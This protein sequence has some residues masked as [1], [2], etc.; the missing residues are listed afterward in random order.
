MPDKSLRVLTVEQRLLFTTIP[1]NL[2]M[3]AKKQ[4][5]DPFEA[6]FAVVD[7][8][9]LV[10]TV[11]SATAHTRL[12]R[13]RWKRHT[14]MEESINP[15]YYELAAFDHLQ[16]GLR[17]GDIAVT[18]SRRYQAFDAYLLS[19][20]QWQQLKK[21]DQTRL[22][23]ADNPL[24]YLQD[25]QEQIVSLMTQVADAVKA[26]DGHLSLAADGTLHLHALEKTVPDEAIAL[27][28]RLYSYDSVWHRFSFTDYA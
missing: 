3:E 7:E 8:M 16:D 25:C 11:D 18:G 20:Q 2:S 15:N 4:E 24:T 21:Q 1:E 13:K 19:P 23:V 28:R 14:L 10:E 27:R 12:K 9:A 5:V 6:V 17:S 26:E 22:A